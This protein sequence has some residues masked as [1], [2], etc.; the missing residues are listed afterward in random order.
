M[1]LNM[2]LSRLIEEGKKMVPMYGKS[3]TGIDNIG[4]SCYINSV[5]QTLLSL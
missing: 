5:L 1:N 4:N 3:F 2:A